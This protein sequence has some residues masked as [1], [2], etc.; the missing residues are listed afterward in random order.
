M[1]EDYKKY[2]I[3]LAFDPCP[4]DPLTWTTPEERGAWF[5]LY[6]RRYNLPCELHVDFDNYENW[7]ALAEAVSGGRPYQFVRWY[8]QG[9]IAVSLRDAEP[10]GEWDAGCAGVI[11]GE[12]PETIR[13]AFTDWAAYAEGEVYSLT[14]TAPDGNEVL[15]VG[16]AYG[17]DAALAYA[18]EAV[19]EDIDLAGVAR[20]R[21]YG[22]RHAPRAREVHA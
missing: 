22:R 9:G 12:S 21:R 19:D 3:A 11:F 2:R 4:E 13:G 1:T 20:I 14:I 10:G 17:Y 15:D 5:V 18:R 6:H 8:E 16:G 7:T